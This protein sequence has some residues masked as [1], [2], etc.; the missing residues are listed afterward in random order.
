MELGTTFIR[1]NAEPE[2]ETSDVNKFLQNLSLLLV[3]VSGFGMFLVIIYG[4]KA[5][6]K[7]KQIEAINVGAFIPSVLEHMMSGEE[8]E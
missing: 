3:S 4:V 6:I 8:Q 2:K 5:D 1:A 7:E